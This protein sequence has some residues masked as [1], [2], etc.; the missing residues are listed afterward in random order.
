M[1]NGDSTEKDDP[2]PGAYGILKPATKIGPNIV[3]TSA[4]FQ[5][6][7][8][9]EPLSF[10]PSR[11][12]RRPEIPSSRP[13][14]RSAADDFEVVS[15]RFRGMMDLPGKF[16]S[17]RALHENAKEMIWATSGELRGRALEVTD[18][19]ERAR[20]VAFAESLDK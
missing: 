1:S 7:D 11:V 20:F 15:T 16:A 12:R 13:S 14:G 8:E 9:P 5:E 4:P 19:Q 3:T 18:R 10:A 17:V 2:P 6:E